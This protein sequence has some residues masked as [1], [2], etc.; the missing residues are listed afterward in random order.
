M[1]GSSLLLAG[2]NELHCSQHFT[3]MLSCCTATA[4]VLLNAQMGVPAAWQQQQQ[5]HVVAVST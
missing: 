1:T 2:S 5:V 4:T 3:V